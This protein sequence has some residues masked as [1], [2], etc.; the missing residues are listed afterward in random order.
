MGLPPLSDFPVVRAAQAGKLR[1]AVDGLTGYGHEVVGAG[2][3][4]GS[5]SG[6]SG[7]SGGLA[8]AHSL[9]GVVNGLRIDE[10]SLVFVAYAMPVSV[11][12]P[13][14]RDQLVVVVPLGPMR[15]RVAGHSTT[16][17]TPFALSG[18]SD[19]TMLPDPVAGALVGAVPV[20]ALTGMLAD[21]FGE[22]REFALDLAQKRPIPIGAGPALR[23]AWL[24][25]ARHPA[26]DPAKL[27]DSLAIGMAPF[28]NYRGAE[29]AEWARPPAYLVQAVRHLRRH[30]A[31]PIS[32]SQLGEVVGIGT[33]QLQLSFQAHLGRTAQEYLRDVRLDHAWALLRDGDPAA[34]G[35]CTVAAVAAEVGIPHTGR[36][37]QYFLERFG[38]LPSELRG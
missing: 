27:L 11:L 1:D 16:M 38:V 3:G 25:F 21:T 19:T 30:L 37:A 18:I 2:S 9:R 35:E 17:V 12:A 28:T 33:R 14:T 7:S 34:G 5:G 20:S 6:V 4:A 32:I 24:E 31:E 29:L 26:A 15:V 36:F 10:L 8:P 13:P 23:R 22:Q